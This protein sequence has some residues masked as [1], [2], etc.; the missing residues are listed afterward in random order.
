MTLMRRLRLAYDKLP[1]KQIVFTALRRIHRPNSKVYWYLYFNGKFKVWIDNSQFFWL[2][3]FGFGFLLENLLFWEGLEGN[4]EKVS[5][6]LWT[7]LCRSSQV[8]FDIGA[9]T[10]VYSLIA[11]TANPESRV[12]AFE[13]VARVYEKLVFNNALNDFDIVC[14]KKAL[15]NFDG[16][17]TIYDLPDYHVYSVTVNENRHQSASNAVP[18]EI[19]TERLSTFIEKHEIATIDL[20]KIDV[21]T[22]EPQVLEGFQP[23]LERFRPTMLIE[24][25][26]DE[27]ATRVETI[28]CDLDYLYFNIDEVLGVRRVDRLTKSDSFNFLICRREIADMLGLVGHDFTPR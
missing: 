3:H 11:K 22:H 1:G 14:V 12:Y 5:M 10:G 27:V 7:R 26:N 20:L 4:W 28:V 15:S 23:Y 9:N 17:A 24:L 6:N 16:R 25:L 13:P 8:V 19:D 2:Q 18:I 21:E